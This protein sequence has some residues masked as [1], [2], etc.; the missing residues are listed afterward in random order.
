MSINIISFFPVFSCLGFFFSTFFLSGEKREC[1]DAA[2][3]F[4]TGF[5][6][7]CGFNV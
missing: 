3:V 7:L 1:K 2:F 4:M 6:S 5:A